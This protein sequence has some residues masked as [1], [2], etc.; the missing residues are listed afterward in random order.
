MRNFA[1]TLI[2]LPISIIIAVA[3]WLAYKPGGPLT[4]SSAGDA[5]RAIKTEPAMQPRA[6]SARLERV[7]EKRRAVSSRDARDPC[8]RRSWR[9]N[10]QRRECE[11]RT[12]SRFTAWYDSHDFTCNMCR[13]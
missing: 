6:A 11:L 3:L 2:A 8:E 7:A 9:R 4:G 12:F 5:V 1:V 10:S 13:G